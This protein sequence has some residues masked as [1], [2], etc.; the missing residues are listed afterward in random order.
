[1]RSFL[2][3]DLFFI[4]FE[5]LVKGIGNKDPEFLYKARK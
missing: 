5:T 2:E 1:M 3:V 4:V